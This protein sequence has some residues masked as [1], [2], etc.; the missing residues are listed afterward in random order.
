MQKVTARSGREK[1]ARGKLGVPL[2]A[3][4]AVFTEK[5]HRKRGIAGRL[6]DMAVEDLRA[7]GISPIYLLTDHIGFYEKYGWEFFCFVQGDGEPF[8]SRM[9]VHK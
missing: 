9:Y 3:N 4:A 2:T 5:N 1:T 7:K 8:E 6:L